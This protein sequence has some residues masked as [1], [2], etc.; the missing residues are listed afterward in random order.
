VLPQQAVERLRKAGGTANGT[1]RGVG[2]LLGT[3]SKTTA[4]RTLHQLQ[5]LGLITMDAG[6]KGVSIALAS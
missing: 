2:K 1:V 4:H 6:P 5:S 3:R